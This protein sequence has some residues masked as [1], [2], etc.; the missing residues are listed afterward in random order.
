MQLNIEIE[1]Y[2]GAKDCQWATRTVSIQGFNRP[3]K[4]DYLCKKSRA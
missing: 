1:E 4:V 3:V 2:V